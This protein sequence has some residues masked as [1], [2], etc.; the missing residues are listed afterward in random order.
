MLTLDHIQKHYANFDLN[1]NLTIPTGQIIGV[2]GPNGAG[3]STLFKLLLNLIQPDQGR[4]LLNGQ[5]LPTW[6]STHP[7]AIS[8]TFPDS[9]FNESLTITA[10]NHLL[11]TFYPTTMATDF[12]AQCQRF[13]L[14]LTQPIKHFSTGMQAK[15]KLLVALSHAATLVV[16]DEPTTGLDVTV[17]QTIIHLIQR[18]HDRYPQAT[19]LISSHIADDIEALAES[20]ILITNGKCQLQADLATI[21]HQYG[22]FTVSQAQFS[23]L[24][25]T[26]INHTWPQTDQVTCLTTNRAAF[27][28]VPNMTVPTVDDLLLRFTTTMEVVA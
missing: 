21:Q 14:P 20:V 15:L 9:G 26:L 17:R 28:T 22:L 23:R 11:T 6:E 4:L 16:L 8:A 25:Q 18:Y 24:D 10:I 5:L 1:L 27:S 7:A 19:I 3:K 13:N 12:L 2:L